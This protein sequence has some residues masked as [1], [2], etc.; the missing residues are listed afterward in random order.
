MTTYRRFVFD[1][2][3][4][5]DNQI[6]LT[7]SFDDDLHFTETITLPQKPLADPTNPDV[8]RALFG[9]HLAGGVSYFKAFCPPEIVVNSG[10]LN[11]QQA[12]FWNEFYTKGLGEF[13]YQ[14]NIDYHDVVN[15]PSHADAPDAIQPTGLP[16]PKKALVPFGGGKD[17]Q[18]TVELLKKRGIDITLFRMKGHRF[19]TE[20]AE[21]NGLPLLELDRA[22]DPQLFELNKQGA[23]NGHV[24]ITGYVTFLALSIALLYGFD[25]I[26]F[27]NERSSDYGNVEYLG[28]EVNH[29]W[30]KSNEAERMMAKYIE[31]FVTRQT[32]YLNALRPLSELAVAKLFV[33]EPRYFSH[34]TSCNQNWLWNKL[35]ENPHTGR[36]CCECDKCAFVFA[37]FAAFLPMEKVVGIFGKN[38]FDDAE[39]LPQ[40]RQ[41]WGAEAF[42]PF[43]CVGTPE[44]TQAAL[45][46]ATRSQEYAN[47]IIG[48]EFIDTILPTIANP[49][50]LVKEQ[51]TPDYRDVPPYIAAII[52][53]ELDA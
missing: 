1:S 15:F 2:Y 37:L 33:R 44:E 4:L 29:Q 39:R 18:V 40:Y 26:F 32:R 38:I 25:S 35:D 36:W 45:Y 11:T 51:L 46:M 52:K 8:Q 28:M 13:F 53:E 3:R 30:S 19:I 23:L 7:Y 16:T 41:L 42:K 5:E 50:A 22:L 10:K 12:A 20:L 6:T 49:K 27:S 9:L 48:K 21:L 17:S 47:T 43:E 14:N 34:V 24:P 31:N